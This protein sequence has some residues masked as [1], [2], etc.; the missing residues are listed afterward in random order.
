[1]NFT[2][3]NRDIYLYFMYIKNMMK[4]KL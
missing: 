3:I 2:H 1:M 4:T